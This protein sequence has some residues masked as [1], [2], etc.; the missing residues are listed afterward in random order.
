MPGTPLSVTT[1]NVRSSSVRVEWSD[2]A[3]PADDGG[4][5]I[6]T[7]RLSYRSLEEGVWS[8]FYTVPDVDVD[9][10]YAV[11]TGLMD[12]TTYQIRMQAGN[13]I[14]KEGTAYIHTFT[15]MYM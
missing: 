13:V 7:I 3:L 11:V 8:E 12:R 9:D 15:Y 14:G 2:H 6:V 10:R 4:A 1:L 5:P